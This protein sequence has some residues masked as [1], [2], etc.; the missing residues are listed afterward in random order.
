[1]ELDRGRGDRSDGQ[2]SPEVVLRSG[3]GGG[4]LSAPGLRTGRL[5]FSFSSSKVAQKACKEQK[6]RRA[7]WSSLLSQAPGKGSATPPRAKTPDNQLNRPLPQ[8]IGRNIWLR[9]SLLITQN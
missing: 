3:E 8:K 5:P 7:N 4:L 6:P 1:M 9:P 2:L